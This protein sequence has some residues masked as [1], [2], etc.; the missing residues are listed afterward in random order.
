M[1]VRC[2]VR[3]AF[4]GLWKAGPLRGLEATLIAQYAGN[5]GANLRDALVT[6]NLSER[7]ATKLPSPM[8]LLGAGI[9]LKQDVAIK[10]CHERD[11]N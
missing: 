2:G 5:L 4:F 6:L 11:P 9:E 3:R 1:D 8:G 7:L 10:R